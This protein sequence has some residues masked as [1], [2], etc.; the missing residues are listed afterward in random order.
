MKHLHHVGYAIKETPSHY[1]LQCSKLKKER[2]AL[3][4]NISSI[5][6]KIKIVPQNV[7]IEELL[8]EQNFSKDDSKTVREEIEKYITSTKPKF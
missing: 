7:L 1:P 5:L 8:G 3:L 4:N 6:S 2:K